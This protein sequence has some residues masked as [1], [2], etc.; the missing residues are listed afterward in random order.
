MSQLS[1]S[2]DEMKRLLQLMES[3]DYDSNNDEPSDL[4]YMADD[5][6]DLEEFESGDL[7]RFTDDYAEPD[8]P[9]AVY[10]LRDW[11][12]EKGRG[13]AVDADGQGWSVQSFQIQHAYVDE[14][15]NECGCDS[16]EM[17]AQADTSINYSKTHTQGDASV[18]VSANAKDL[19]Q[20]QAVLRL[21]GVD[22]D[23]AQAHMHEPEPEVE[24]EPDMP[25]PFGVRQD[26]RYSTDAEFIRDQLRQR[27][28]G[29]M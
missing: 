7:V 9:D 12:P 6:D 1:N 10:T 28:Q 8:A 25:M 29:L 2:Q 24:P 21:A 5:D 16:S 13:W 20:L 23:F 26:A 19:S 3:M 15:L 14:S 4:D 17:S 18:T 11:D 27:M 22:A